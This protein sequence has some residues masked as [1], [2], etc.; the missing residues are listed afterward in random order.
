MPKII[1]SLRERI[2][3]EATVLFCKLGFQKVDMKTI[4]KSCDIA[5]G[6]LYNYYP[7][8][9]ELYIS[10]V[11]ESWDE[12]FRK[13]DSI[14]IKSE[15]K[16][17][18]LKAV[19]RILYDDIIDRQGIGAD[20]ATVSR[21]G[22]SEFIDVKNEFIEKIFIILNKFQLNDKY[23]EYN[24]IQNK[25][26][27]MLLANIVIMI[28]IDKYNVEENLITIVDSIKVFYK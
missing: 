18:N 22:K 13:M 27:N 5:V 9:K 25:I 28:S 8:K 2:K 16:E 14:I 24:G 11:R 19:I 21:D 3:E 4:A 20:V 15:E 10:I 23:K 1:N 12:T 26:A 17:E 7:N 6:T